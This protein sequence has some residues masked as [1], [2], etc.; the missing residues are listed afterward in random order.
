MIIGKTFIISNRLPVKI[1]RKKNKL[2][3]TRSEGGL[4]TGLGSFY[5]EDGSWWLGWPGIIPKNTEE[6]EFIRKELHSLNLIPVFLTPEDIKGYYEGFSNAV[7]WPLCHYRPSFVDFNEAYWNSYLNVNNKFASEALKH[8][9]NDTNIWIHDYQLMALPE[10][11]R[12]HDQSFTIGYFHH[13]PFP[14]EELFRMLPWRGQLLKGLLGADL[15]GFHTFEDTQNFLNSCSSNLRMEAHYNNLKCNGRRIFVEAFPMGID[16]EKFKNAALSQEVLQKAREV[17]EYYRNQKIILSVDR[18]DYSKGIIER[19]R[20]LERLLKSHPEMIG[21]IV[22]Y[23]LIVPSRDEVSAYK[24]LRN[25][26]DRLVGNINAVYGRPGWSPVAYFYQSVPFEELSALYV[27]AD[28]CFVNSIRDG[29]NLVAK[30]YIASK[31]SDKRGV[32]LLSEFT[33]ASKELTDAVLINPHDSIKVSASLYHAL[34]MPVKEQKERIQACQHIVEKFHVHH[35]VKLFMERLQE[36]KHLQRKELA[37]KVA[38]SIKSAIHDRYTNS[39]NRLF[40][41]DYDGTLVGININAN[42]AVPTEEVYNLIDSLTADPNN[43]VVIIS[44][45]RHLE[46]EKWF[47][48]K[49]VYLIGEHGIWTNY[50]D[51]K[52]RAKKGISNKWKTHIKEILQ[53]YTDRTPGAS[54]EEKS[55]AVAWHYRKVQKGL[56]LLQAHNL[57]VQLKNLASDYG[58]QVV[59]GDE[60][61]EIKVMQTNKGKAAL[62]LVNTMTP[63]F[64]LSIGDD[65]TDEDM[66]QELPSNTISVKVGDKQSHAKFYVDTQIDA[67]KFLKSFTQLNVENTIQYE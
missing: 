61:V 35:W 44:G 49:S 50:P 51:K 47:G 24:K 58:L 46:L 17:K 16:Y 38:S 60:V 27:A 15:I 21:K 39:Q 65:T 4:A 26:I 9:D 57:I 59:H 20:A 23:M 31:Q 7:L 32:L 30:E 34:N 3:V 8:L 29:M 43:T 25:D 53:H 67:L 64:I 66:F 10:L 48:K 52:W 28:I 22:L 62:E 12:K 36:T 6:E 18:L 40:F 54:I 63:D 42:K 45:R 1:E 2:V 37:R 19:L 33:G 11:L 13:I 41:L 5:R 56:G 55:Y 14:P